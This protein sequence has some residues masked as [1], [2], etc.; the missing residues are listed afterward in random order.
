MKIVKS[1]VNTLWAFFCAVGQAKYA[2]ELSRN[3]KWAEAQALYKNK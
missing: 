2:A 3:G 1:I